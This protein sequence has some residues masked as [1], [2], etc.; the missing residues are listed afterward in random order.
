LKETN[1]VTMAC[2]PKCR[3]MVGV[4][5]A[6]NEHMEDKMFEKKR[7]IA[8][9]VAGI[10]ILASA[11]ITQAGGWMHKSGGHEKSAKQEMGTVYAPEFE[12]G[13][14]GE[15]IETGSLPSPPRILESDEVPGWLN[16]DEPSTE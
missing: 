7:I 8:L 1:P 13:D 11:G 15:V 6:P 3:L 16:F 9:M 12:P 4:N 14:L 2:T 5:I 10:F